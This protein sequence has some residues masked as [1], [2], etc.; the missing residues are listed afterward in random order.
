M[1]SDFEDDQKSY[2]KNSD[3]GKNGDS[4]EYNFTTMTFLPLKKLN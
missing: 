4:Q 1:E 2:D 3:I